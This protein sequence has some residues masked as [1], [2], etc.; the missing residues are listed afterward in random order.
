M[1]ALV[2]AAVLLGLAAAPPAHAAEL[3]TV[4]RVSVAD[5]KAV[6]A[7]VESINV[8][9]ARARIGGTVAELK[10]KEGARVEAGQVVA[11]IEATKSSF[12]K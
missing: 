11:T 7:T 2:L 6:F 5:E 8:V 1:H 3:F 9:P 12:S 4:A 10:V